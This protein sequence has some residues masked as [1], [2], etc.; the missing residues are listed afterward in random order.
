MLQ[1]LRA[2]QPQPAAAKIFTATRQHKAAT[3]LEHVLTRIIGVYVDE[4]TAF[5]LYPYNSAFIGV[6]FVG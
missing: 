3:A 4:L 6:Y 2:L 5:G 1:C